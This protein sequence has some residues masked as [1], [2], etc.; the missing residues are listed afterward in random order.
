MDVEN[1]KIYYRPYL[2]EKLEDIL[3]KT[4]ALYEEYTP[5]STFYALLSKAELKS[6]REENAEMLIEAGKYFKK[7][8]TASSYEY[9]MANLYPEIVK[10]FGK[11]VADISESAAAGAVFPL[12]KQVIEAEKSAIDTTGLTKMEKY[13]IEDFFN[14][15]LTP[16]RNP[17]IY[18]K[19]GQ[20]KNYYDK[21]GKNYEFQADLARQI[22]CI[23]G[24]CES[25]IEIFNTPDEVKEEEDLDR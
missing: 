1:R 13:M 8:V 23:R 7:D 20:S 11:D 18:A 17:N 25:T 5:R 9:Y 4:I 3:D 14:K 19:E 21:S 24:L 12:Y 22:R 6:G 2:A 15:L 10:K 16:T